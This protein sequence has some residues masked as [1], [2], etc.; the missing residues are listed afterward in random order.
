MMKPLTAT[1]HD[2]QTP[3]GGSRGPS[4]SARSDAFSAPLLFPF[5]SGSGSYMI[6]EHRVTFIVECSDLW[7][8][9]CLPLVARKAGELRN[10][11]KH[12]TGVLI[13][14]STYKEK[15]NMSLLE[16]FGWL[17]SPKENA[18]NFSEEPFK[19]TSGACYFKETFSQVL[20]GRVPLRSSKGGGTSQCK[21]TSTKQVLFYTKECYD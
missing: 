20:F 16:A 9:T 17:P 3:G 5:T 21:L 6:T 13:F 11:H 7:P 19:P 12:S 8:Q 14:C 15:K 4:S 10:G 1:Q 2:S 18:T